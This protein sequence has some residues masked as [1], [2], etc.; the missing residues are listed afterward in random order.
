MDL[1]L[2][3]EWR[4]HRL[5]YPAAGSNGSD[6]IMLDPEEVLDSLWRPDVYFKNAKDVRFHERMVPNHYVWFYPDNKIVY[7]AKYTSCNNPSTIGG[8]LPPS[9]TTWTRHRSRARTTSPGSAA[10]TASAASKCAT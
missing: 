8:E 5:V 3:Q 7:M 4:D 1:F 9:A 10:S 2:A 6:H